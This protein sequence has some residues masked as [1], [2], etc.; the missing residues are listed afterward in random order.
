M[1]EIILAVVILAVMGLIFG[2]LLTIFSII[3]YVKED[4]RIGEVEKLLPGANCGA[5]GYPGCH[6][7]AE[8]L[9]KG[10]ASKVSL[11]KVGKPDKNFQPII[12]Y[13]DAHPNDDGTKVKITQ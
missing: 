11:C 7:L 1:S 6:G 5:C 3:F 4:E 2:V 13:M 9:V 12:A 8:A 10:E